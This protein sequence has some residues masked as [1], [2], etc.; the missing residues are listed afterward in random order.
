LLAPLNL[1]M[2]LHP[3][4]LLLFASVT[5][6]SC[7]VTGGNQESAPSLHIAYNT[8]LPN[9]DSG[10]YEIFLMDFDG[11][12]SRN[13]T[14]SPSVDW[15]LHAQ[16]SN[17]FFLSDR[18]T[19]EGAYF[20][21]RMNLES[22]EMMKVLPDRVSNSWIDTHNDGRE[23]LLCKYNGNQKSIVIV[24]SLGNE[25]R[26]IVTTDKYE[27]SDPI[28][29]NDGN[30][31]IFRSTR[32]GNDELWIVDILGAHQRRLTHY[33]EDQARPSAE[34]YQT[35]PPR[36]IPNTRAVSFT[37]RRDGNYNIYRVNIDGTDFQEVTSGDGDEGWH[38]WSPDGEML[39][40]DG[41]TR[42][43]GN[44]EIFLMKADGSEMRQLTTTPYM[45][46][47]PVF[48]SIVSHEVL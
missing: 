45:E 19:I 3:W 29:S 35:G 8:I 18:D 15:L 36:W 10:N 44:S 26:E 6:A 11:N 43:D 2:S 40:F 23:I 39:I 25:M 24:D 46:R 33:P 17:I 38:S 32:S 21:Y 47:A 27:I 13:L 31:V 9:G 30:W 12:E 28:F 4:T 7:Y 41:S 5:M 34:F 1:D 20:L 14:N 37:S 48:V 16:G 22:R 42:K